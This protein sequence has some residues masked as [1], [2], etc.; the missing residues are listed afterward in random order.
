LEKSNLFLENIIKTRDK[1]YL[2]RKV[3][4]LFKHPVSNGGVWNMAVEVKM[5]D[6]MVSL[7]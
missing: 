6:K 7:P 4:W 3:E 1:I 5:Q 2:D